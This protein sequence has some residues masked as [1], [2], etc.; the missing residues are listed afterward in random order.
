MRFIAD[1]RR[2]WSV[3]VALVALLTV[4]TFGSLTDLLL[5]THEDEIFRDHL[6]ADALRYFFKS[7]AEKEFNSPGRPITEIAR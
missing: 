6:K 2:T 1:D 4:V 7:A 3:Y 5:D